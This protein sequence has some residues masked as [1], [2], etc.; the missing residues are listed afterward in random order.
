MQYYRETESDPDFSSESNPS[1]LRELNLSDNKLGDSGVKKPQRSTDEHT[2]QA[3]ETTVSIIILYSRYS[4]I[5]LYCV[6]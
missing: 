6:V 3:G 4:L 1:H 5:K 2:M